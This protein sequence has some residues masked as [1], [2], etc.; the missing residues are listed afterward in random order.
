MAVADLNR[1][2]AGAK[3]TWRDSAT[4]LTAIDKASARIFNDLLE[5]RKVV[6]LFDEC[7]E[8]FRS[9]SDPNRQ[10]IGMLRFIVPGMLP[11]LQRLKKHGERHGVIVVATNYYERLDSAIIRPGRIDE[12]FL[13]SPYDRDSRACLIDDMLRGKKL[14]P[15]AVRLRIARALADWTPGWVYKEI[16]GTHRSFHRRM[17]HDRP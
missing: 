5:L 14:F 15:D 2:P 6:V 12:R 16:D 9:R 10:D 13:A 17:H 3:P 7:D 11:K 8:M 4:V 1:R